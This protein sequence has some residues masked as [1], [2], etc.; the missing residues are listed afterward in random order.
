MKVFVSVT[1]VLLLLAALSFNEA[2]SQG[3]YI[4]NGFGGAVGYSN[5]NDVSV[6][7]GSVG[8]VAS[9]IVEFGVGVAYSSADE[10]DLNVIGVAPYVA[11]YP[12]RQGRAVPV[13]ARIIGAY[14]FDS[15]SGDVVEGR[16]ISGHAIGLGG[17][18][19]RSFR[20][21]PS[22]AIVPEIGV[23][24]VRTTISGSFVSDTESTTA[25]TLA[26]AFQFDAATTTVVLKPRMSLAEGD[27][28]F[29]VS[30]IFGV[31]Q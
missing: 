11:L 10:I 24:Y 2:Q 21:T 22:V 13:T 1:L 3:L 7:S 26:L 25:M 5:N 18:I 17:S 19:A 4:A 27:T 15:F 20:A 9:G 12:V 8:Y 6:I 31:G 28:A 23:A 30:A 14:E 16:D 29:G